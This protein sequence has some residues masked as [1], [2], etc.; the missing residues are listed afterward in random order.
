M[1]IR[2]AIANLGREEDAS[3]KPNIQETHI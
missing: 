1:L 2:L 3:D